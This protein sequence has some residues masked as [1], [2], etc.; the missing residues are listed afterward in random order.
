MK[1]FLS[2]F[3]IFAVTVSLSACSAKN[4]NHTSSSIPYSN[5]SSNVTNSASPNA[6]SSVTSKSKSS[7]IADD[8]K[9]NTKEFTYLPSYANAQVKSFTPASKSN[10]GFGTAKYTIKNSNRND[11]LLNYENTLK[12]SGWAITRDEKPNS[13]CAKKGT[14]NVVLIPTITGKDITLIVISK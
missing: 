11:I 12:K 13:V 14:H 5:V 8:K 1:K 4:S 6:S 10:G 2:V 7:G 3:V 9:A